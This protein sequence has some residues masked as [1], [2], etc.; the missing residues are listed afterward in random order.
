MLR[1]PKRLTI[2]PTMNRS[3][4][5]MLMI[6][7]TDMHPNIHTRTASTRT[8]ILTH[9]TSLITNRIVSTAARYR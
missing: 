8:P 2:Q 4:M 6:T 7:I 1:C 3:A 9:T 5:Q